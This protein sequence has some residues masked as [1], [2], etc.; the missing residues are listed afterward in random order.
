MS[1]VITGH[2][3]ELWLHNGVSLIE[4]GEIID[5]PEFPSGER[6]LIETSH[7]KTMDY[8]SYISAPLKE[9]S[10]VTIV[11]N[12]IPESAT[13]AVCADAEA[14]GKERDYKIVYLTA[15]NV[16]RKK[17][18]TLLVRKYVVKNP[19]EDRRTGELTIKWTSD[20]VDA[21]DI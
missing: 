16:R 7:M 4:L 21:L 11:M 20:A 3:T 12:Y 15:D 6:D 5:V 19:M 13:D 9:G 1:E 2:K 8:K 18:G 10:E 14:D 17:T